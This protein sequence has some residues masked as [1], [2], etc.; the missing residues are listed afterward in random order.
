MLKWFRRE[1]TD[2]PD[3]GRRGFFKAG[4]GA[5][6]GGAA[7]VASGG[8]A[9]AESGTV[10]DPG[11]TGYRETEHVRRFYESARM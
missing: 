7:V 4:A 10:K 3:A 1:R 8:A 2:A 5:V 9:R 11:G 6:V